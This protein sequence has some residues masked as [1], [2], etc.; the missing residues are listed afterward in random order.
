MGEPAGATDPG[1][2]Y[3]FLERQL[4]VPTQALHGCK[5]SEVAAAGAPPGHATFVFLEAVLLLAGT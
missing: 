3:D 4:F 2:E 5:D 1:Y